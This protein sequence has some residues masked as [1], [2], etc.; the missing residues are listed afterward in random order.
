[1]RSI[2]LFSVISLASILLWSSFTEL[3]LPVNDMPMEMTADSLKLKAPVAVKEIIQA[4][5]YDCHAEGGEEEAMKDLLWDEFP[6]L[7]PEDQMYLL[8]DIVESIEDKEMPPADHLKEHPED[9]LTRQEARTLIEWASALAN[10][11]DQG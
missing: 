8:D 11:L 3:S 1:M 2:S 4:K 5:C 10:D 9:K 6:S 7:H